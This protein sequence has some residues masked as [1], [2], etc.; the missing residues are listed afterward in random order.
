MEITNDTQQM[1]EGITTEGR[2]SLESQLPPR[3]L[4][5]ASACISQG[6]VPME[7]EDGAPGKWKDNWLRPL[8]CSHPFTPIWLCVKSSWLTH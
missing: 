1:K 8:L 4:L 7:G 2:V 5:L 3:K 6:R